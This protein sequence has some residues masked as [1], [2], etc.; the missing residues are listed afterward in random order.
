MTTLIIARHGNTF[1]DGE[2][3]RRVGVRTDLPLTEKGRE[4]A[5]AIGRW[6]KDNNKKPDAVFCSRLRRTCE[7][8]EIAMIGAGC[9][10]HVQQEAMFNEIDY[11]PDE[12]KTDEEVIA[13]IGAQALKDW[14]ER[15]VVPPGWKADPQEIARNWLAFGARL[16][17]DYSGCTILVVTS[18]GIARFAPHL[19][20]NF[21]A[22]SA[23]HALKISTGALCVL[24]SAANGWAVEAWNIRPSR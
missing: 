6:L 7:T 17:R 21:A 22:F 9:A 14:D 20:G 11:G 12:N 23:A 3:P 19:T 15:A 10:L 13:R 4:Q 5:R 2:R 18:N 24:E 1:E 8:A 16:E